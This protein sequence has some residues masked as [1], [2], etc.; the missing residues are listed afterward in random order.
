M[1]S[2]IIYASIITIVLPLQMQDNI[3]TPRDTTMTFT[4][5]VFFDMFNA[6]SCRSMTKSIVT[7]GLT[8]NKTFVIAVGASLLGQLLVI[9]FPPLQ[10]V[11]LTEP[12]YLSDLLLLA[13]LTSTVLI[14]DEL[15]KFL[16]SQPIPPYVNTMTV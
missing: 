12:L 9:Y 5:F 7:I 8:S 13:T 11:F 2:K 14:V 10:A 1:I 15:R 16:S 4:C 6:L 3:I